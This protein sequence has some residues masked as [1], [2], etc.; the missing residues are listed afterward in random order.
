MLA[1]DL[2]QLS[3]FLRSDF[4]YETGPFEDYD[5][6]TP[7]K[8]FLLR[9]DFNLNNSNKVSFRYNHLD[10]ITD[11]GL[12]ELGVARPRPRLQQ[13]QL[14]E[15]PELELPDSREHPVRHRRV[16]LDPRQHACRTA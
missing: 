13:H 16:E 6:L 5:D 14:P 15:L 10:S 11:V 1:S 3:S 2:T 7:A 4:S 12:S 8:R 9:N